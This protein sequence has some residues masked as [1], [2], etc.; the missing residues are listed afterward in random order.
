MS[1]VAVAAGASAAFGPL[2]PPQDTVNTMKNRRINKDGFD[3][4]IS[5]QIRL[6]FH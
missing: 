6:A 1:T 4:V 5:T 2:P 3:L